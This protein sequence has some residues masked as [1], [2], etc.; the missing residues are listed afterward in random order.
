MVFNF[1]RQVLGETTGGQ[2]H[3]ASGPDTRRSICQME[4][5][6]EL[7]DFPFPPAALIIR[8]NQSPSKWAPASSYRGEGRTQ[9]IEESIRDSLAAKL[10]IIPYKQQLIFLTDWALGCNNGASTAVCATAP[11]RFSRLI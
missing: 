7:A 3:M 2:I 9:H 8:D 4:L 1:G 11:L 6:G 5:C 10:K